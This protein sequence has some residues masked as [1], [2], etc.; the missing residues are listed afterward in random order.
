MT[1]HPFFVNSFFITSRDGRTE[2]V[3]DVAPYYVHLKEGEFIEFRTNINGNSTP[4]SISA[5]VEVI[6]PVV[7]SS[8]QQ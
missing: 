2:A 5:K 1:N 3:K 4:T 7:D 8:L 6:E